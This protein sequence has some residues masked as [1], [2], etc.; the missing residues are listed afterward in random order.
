MLPRVVKTPSELG[1]L[2]T[3][4]LPYLQQQDPQLGLKQIRLFSKYQIFSL[5]VRQ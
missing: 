2:Q 4:K 3:K 5:K 1:W